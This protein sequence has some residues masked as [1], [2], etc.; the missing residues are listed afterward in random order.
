MREQAIREKSE[1]RDPLVVMP[2]SRLSP[3]S[4][5]GNVERLSRRI[6]ARKRRRRA[7]GHSSPKFGQSRA[8]ARN[9][10]C[11]EARQMNSCSAKRVKITTWADPTSAGECNHSK[12]LKG[13][14]EE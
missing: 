4:T 12:K 6:R 11:K 14:N 7:S 5:R 3:T 8:V 1:N 9:S 13:N 2:L 10:D